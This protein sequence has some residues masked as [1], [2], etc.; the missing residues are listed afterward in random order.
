MRF[1]VYPGAYAICICSVARGFLHRMGVRLR[2]VWLDTMVSSGRDCDGKG[3]GTEREGGKE[4]EE[5]RKKEKREKR[6]SIGNRGDTLTNLTSVG[7]GVQIL[8]LCKGRC[9]KPTV[10]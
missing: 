10:V 7:D 2:G 4:M 8:L 6:G 1:G 5:K 9:S 3:K